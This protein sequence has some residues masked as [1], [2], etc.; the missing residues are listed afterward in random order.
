MPVSIGIGGTFEF[1]IGTVSRAPLWVQKG[2]LEWIYRLIVE[3]RRLWKRYAI[4][5][6]KFSLHAGSAIWHSRG[7]RGS[8]D[9]TGAGILDD[10]R[11][12][13]VAAELLIVKLPSRFDALAVKELRPGIETAWDNGRQLILD[14][15][16]VG[17]I[18]SSG[19]GYLVQL[20]RRDLEG[21]RRLNLVAL[22][23]QVMEF[24][25]FN[26][27][28]TLFSE[29]LFG[30]ASLAIVRIRAE[31]DEVR[32]PYRLTTLQNGTVV[33][34]LSG[35]L[36]ALAMK[37]FPFQALLPQLEGHDCILDL[38]RLD[39][40][41]SS[42]LVAF[43]RIHRHLAAGGNSCTL[44]APN[45]PVLQL[46]RI[47]RMDSFFTITSNQFILGDRSQT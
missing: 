22:N 8:R 17:M 9:V 47:T 5:L 39:F 1:I 21:I 35:R 12:P 24:L 30:N 27:V 42:G 28:A 18:D 37:Q 43:H 32:A 38:S 45:E 16:A 15:Q 7:G 34:A 25:A 33:V 4:G 3:P 23:D 19:L 11:L 29:R 26:R 44:C 14:F 2:G 40:V 6:A 31:Q 46:L 41:D 36:G 13:P 10:S 20:W